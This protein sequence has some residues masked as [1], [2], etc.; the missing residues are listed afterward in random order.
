MGLFDAGITI[1]LV[2]VRCF[3]CGV[4]FG[5]ESGRKEELTESHDSFWC[6]NGHAQHFVGQTEKE[7]RIAQL[8]R[9]VRSNKSSADFW[10]EQSASAAKEVEHQSR[11]INGYKGVV[12]RTKRR[13]AAGRCP[14]CSAEFKNLESHMKAKHPNYDPAK[15]AEHLAEK[16]SG[17]A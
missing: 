11:R 1:S 13:V 10:R 15:G 16:S 12:A 17:L 14:C 3:K 5:I 9:D 8:E 2:T 7:K 6:P 4:I